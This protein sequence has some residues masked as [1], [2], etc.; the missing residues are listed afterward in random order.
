MKK[1]WLVFFVIMFCSFSKVY[2]QFTF[3][4]SPGIALRS[5]YFGFKVKDNFVPSFGLQILNG[6]YKYESI[7]KEWDYDQDKVVDIVW[8]DEFSG[9]LFVLNFSV[10]YF[11]KEVNN[12][13]PYF[14]INICKPLFSAKAI[15]D[16]EEDKDLKDD[17]NAIKVWG[18]EIGF[19]T[20]Y[21]FSD[22]FSLGG[23][24]GLRYFYLKSKITYDDQY[25]NPNLGYVDYKRESN[26]TYIFR[27]TYSSLL[28]NY[29]F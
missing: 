23:E 18:G 26:S 29:Y 16:G 2:S 24:F 27:P 12:I 5:A 28:L 14:S 25:Y 8:E 9:T 20:E 7:I 17:L 22:N 11:I 6:K 1:I 3:G 15:Y 13:K 10:K 19:G 21:F 4:V